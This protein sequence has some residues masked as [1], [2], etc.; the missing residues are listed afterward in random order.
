MFQ[1]VPKFGAVLVKFDESYPYGEAQDAFKKVAEATL[2]QTELL[3]AE[4]NIAGEQ[5]ATFSSYF[6]M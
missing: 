6:C 4:V 1:I 2:S 3:L 5:A